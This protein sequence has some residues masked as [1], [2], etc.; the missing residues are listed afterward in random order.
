MMLNTRDNL[1]DVCDFCS[2][3][4]LSHIYT[5]IRSKRGMEVVFVII[6]VYLRAFQPSLINQD[7]L[8]TYLVMLKKELKD[9]K[10]TNFWKL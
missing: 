1:K 3:E 2:S 5:P 10:G 8:A 6:V 7:L 4:N 9:Y